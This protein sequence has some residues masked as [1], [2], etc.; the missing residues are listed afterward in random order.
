[1]KKTGKIIGKNTIK[2]EDGKFIIIPPKAYNWIQYTKNKTCIVSAG[3][4]ILDAVAVCNG[5]T[6]TSTGFRRIV[7]NEDSRATLVVGINKIGHKSDCKSWQKCS[8]EDVIIEHR[9]GYEEDMYFGKKITGF[10]KQGVPEGDDISFN[11]VKDILNEIS[12]N[13]NEFLKIT[14]L[15]SSFIP[16]N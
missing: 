6:L 4:F 5:K 15:S 11:R 13:L 10:S 16:L 8:I 3:N 12:P 1:M 2:T 14:G 9:W 7:L